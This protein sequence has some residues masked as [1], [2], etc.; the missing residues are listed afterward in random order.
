MRDSNID[1][2]NTS[3]SKVLIAMSNARKAQIWYDVRTD[4]REHTDIVQVDDIEKS[5][6]I[7]KIWLEGSEE[8]DYYVN[9]VHFLE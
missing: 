1:R 5:G 9:G 2:L 6:D 8:P 3:H 4:E 7:I